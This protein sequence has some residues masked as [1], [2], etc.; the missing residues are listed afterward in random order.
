[1]TLAVAIGANTT[2]FS[3]LEGVLLTP[4]PYPHEDR[5]VRVAATVHDR[6]DARRDRG[7]TFSDP[8]YRRFANNNR[9]F[10]KFGGYAGDPSIRSRSPRGRSGFC[11]SRVACELVVRGSGGGHEPTR[12]AAYWMTCG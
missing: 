1:L 5:I 10:E 8:G 11:G 12:R 9:S 3:V 4:L 2:I 6:G 7:N